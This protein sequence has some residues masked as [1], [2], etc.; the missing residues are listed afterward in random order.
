MEDVSQFIKSL[1]EAT[2]LI[3]SKGDETLVL[4]DLQEKLHKYDTSLVSGKKS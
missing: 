3:I 4:A 2:D 1:E